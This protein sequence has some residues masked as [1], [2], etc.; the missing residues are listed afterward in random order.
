MIKLFLASLF[1]RTADL[2]PKFHTDLAGR[3]VCF[4]PTAAAVGSPELKGYLEDERR[5]LKGLGLAIDELEVSAAPPEEISS[6]IKSAD[7]VF[8][9]GGN[10]FFLIQEL[11]RTGADQLIIDHI[12][13]SKLYIATSA[14][15]MI[16]SKNIEYARLMDPPE[17]AP[18]LNG[19]FRGLG[20]VDFGIA[21]HKTD[22]HHKQSCALVAREYGSRQEIICLGDDEVVTVL[23]G[24]HEVVS[25]KSLK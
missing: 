3:K 14:G 5:A 4:I 18:L 9:S 16:V 12:D 13:R 20:L 7:F 2:L 19:D 21:P 1:F 25:V 15:S 17:K 24:R 10:T 23:G 6:K 11:R 8:V 22:G